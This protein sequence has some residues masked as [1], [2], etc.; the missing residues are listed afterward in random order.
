M[1]AAQPV[2]NTPHYVVEQRLV[3]ITFTVRDGRGA[4]R[5]DLDRSN[6]EAYEDGARREITAF[7]REQELPLTLGVMFETKEVTAAFL[8]ESRRLTLAFLRGVMRPEDRVFLVAMRPD[9]RL[10]LDETGSEAV[11]ESVF[12]DLDRN[13]RA[14][15]V[16]RSGFGY[17]VL[18]DI[19]MA[20]ERKLAK[21]RGRKAIVLIQAGWDWRSQTRI[22]D[23]I[24]GLQRADVIVYHLRIPNTI[25]KVRYVNPVIGPLDLLFVRRPMS[26]ICAQTGGYQF[27]ESEFGGAFTTIEQELRSSYTVAFRPGR[28]SPD[29]NLHRIAVR[30]LQPG[31][32]VRHRPSYLDTAR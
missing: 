23:L 7:S 8:E 10:L 12:A 26:R 1:G 16:W 31:L 5:P 14:A 29:G 6:F 19:A 15:P 18:D 21:V 4:F 24:E 28:A 22:T 2:Q 20:L 9:T 27:K 13:V 25:D 17:K 32:S 30:S 11:V 3:N